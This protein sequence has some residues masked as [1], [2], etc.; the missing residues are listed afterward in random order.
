MSVWLP[1]LQGNHEMTQPIKMMLLSLKID[2]C[3]EAYADQF[4]MTVFLA[5]GITPFLF[6]FFSWLEAQVLIFCE[7]DNLLDIFLSMLW[8]LILFQVE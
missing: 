7:V 1:V 2:C 5:R 3:H 8:K 4:L 6:L